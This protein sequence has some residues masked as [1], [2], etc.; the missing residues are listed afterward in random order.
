MY[1]DVYLLPGAIDRSLIISK[2]RSSTSAKR[3][4]RRFQQYTL[5]QCKKTAFKGRIDVIR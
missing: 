2:N 3:V 1:R 4:K 5:C